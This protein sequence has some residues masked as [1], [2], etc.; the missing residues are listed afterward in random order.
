[1]K[2][3]HEHNIF[4]YKNLVADFYTVS[5]FALWLAAYLLDGKTLPKETILKAPKKEI[6]NILIYNHYEGTQHG[7]ILI[8]KAG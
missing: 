5:S 4:V 1:M 6:K 3:L 8:S 7:F 2:N